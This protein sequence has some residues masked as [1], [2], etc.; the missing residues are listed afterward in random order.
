MCGS[1]GDP[2]GRTQ[3]APAALGNCGNCDGARKLDV[4]RKD[5]VWPWLPAEPGPLS[6]PVKPVKAPDVP[7]TGKMLP[8]SAVAESST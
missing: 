7:P 4:V 6:V 1:K 5:A 8:S 2:P 3:P